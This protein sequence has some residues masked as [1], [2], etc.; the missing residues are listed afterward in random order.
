M[1]KKKSIW[2]QIIFILVAGLAVSFI[3]GDFQLSSVMGPL[4]GTDL[5]TILESISLI[6]GFVALTLLAIFLIFWGAWREGGE[7]LESREED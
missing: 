5:E 1:N 7:K 6:L 4:Q 3:T 2:G